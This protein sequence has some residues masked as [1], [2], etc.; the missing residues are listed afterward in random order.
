MSGGIF[1]TAIVEP[2]YNGFV[3]LIDITPGGSVGVAIVVL[4]LLVRTLLLPLSHSASISQVK[5][6]ALAP[7]LEAIKKKYEKDRALQSKKTFEL[8]QQHHLNPFSSCLSAIIQIPVVLGLFYVFYR[9]Y[10]HGIVEHPELLYS[11][12]SL[13]D[14]VNHT[15]LGFFDMDGR[16][17]IFAFLAA[18]A[19][20]LQLRYMSPFPTSNNKD[21]RGSFGEE[22]MKNMS[23]QMKYTLPIIIFVGAYFTSTAAALYWTTSNIFSFGHEWY[24][25]KKVARLGIGK[26]AGE[27][28]A[29]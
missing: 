25:R 3:F 26:V 10:P 11:F 12:I 19:Q 2:L 29:R 16:S 14:A 23:Q 1:S 17:A 24:V 22:L 20:F 13:P 15:F 27:E 21:K 28:H 5:M 18:A 6:R 8:Y 7:E 4:T 9:W